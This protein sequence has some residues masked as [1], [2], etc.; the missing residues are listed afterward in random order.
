MIENV[1]Q[2]AIKAELLSELGLSNPHQVPKIEKIIVAA[3]VGTL[4]QKDKKIVKE[5]Q[6]NLTLIAGQKAVINKAKKSISNF[7]LREDMPVGV[8]VTLRGKRA[9][10]FL[11]N[12]INV[13]FP[14]VRDFRG[15]SKKSFDG[16]GNISVGIKEHLV[17]PE[18]NPDD[19]VEIHG[20]Q[21]VI[22]TSAVNDEQGYALLRKYN[23]PFKEKN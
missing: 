23:F 13:V 18:M 21:I 19:L 8:S 10:D 3:G 5:V 1:T 14:R 17:F 20:L 15:Y 4:A 2:G 16:R 11:N 6:E 7:K 9:N 22:Q 12:L